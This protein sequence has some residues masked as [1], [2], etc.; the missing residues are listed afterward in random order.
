MAVTKIWKIKH[1]FAA[2]LKYIENEE[3]T[4]NPK[5]AE[6]Y[7][8]LD[9]VIEYAARED[10]T[11]QKF[12]VSSLNC[13]REHARDEFLLTK[14]RFD[15]EDGIV[16]FHAYQSFAEEDITPEVAHEIGIAFAKELWGDRFQ[17]VIATHLNTEHVHNHF[18]IN[19]VSF[20]D[21]KK[22]HDSKAAYRRMREVSDR[23]CREHG[24][25]VIE[26]PEGKGGSYYLNKLER[27]EMPTRYNVAR[28]AIDEAI[29]RSVNM[30]EFRHELKM[31]GYRYQFSSNRRYWT[32]TPAGWDRPIRLYRL[33]AD[34]TEER[35]RQRVYENDISVRERRLARA[36]YYPNRYDLRR[37]VDRIMGRSGLEKLY[38][39]YCYELGYLPKY[40]QKLAKL[41]PLLRE[42]LLKCEMYSQQARLL[43]R[44]GIETE[45]DL[46]LHM[47]RI[48]KRSEEVMRRRQDLQR[49]VRR[50]S[51]S[52]D[53][54]A[55][56]KAEIADLSGRLKE[57]RK[58]MRLCENIRERSHQ[59]EDRLAAVD[60]DRDERKRVRER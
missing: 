32:I 23:L 10:K 42:D 9:D 30:E 21:G 6:N 51:V 27:D 58:E 4:A 40:N 48:R 5:A 26:H 49:L 3:K 56:A 18:V 22:Y 39:R 60:R 50:K 7:Q 14:K 38:L 31:M 8:M 36:A 47:E 25:S 44:N 54:K 13:D 41:H 43:C 46:L 45:A 33:G 53:E 15:K 57:L 37:R 55:K 29:S 20:L 17:V 12:F 11:E 34:Y 35:I 52:E 1:S 24:L 28:Q 2:P 16:A 19:S 59:L